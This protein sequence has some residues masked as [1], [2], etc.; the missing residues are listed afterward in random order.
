MRK[1]NSVYNCD[2]LLLNNVL[3]NNNV[4]GSVSLVQQNINKGQRTEPHKR[5]NSSINKQI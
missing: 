4:I 2:L 3:V 1:I 5:A